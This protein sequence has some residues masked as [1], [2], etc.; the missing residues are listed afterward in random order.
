M[1]VKKT[2]KIPETVEIKIIPDS[3]LPL[4]RVYSNYVE[5]NH[6][7]FDFT[8]RFCDTTPIRNMEEVKKNGGKHHIPVVA[9]IALPVIII[10]SLINALRDQLK[11]YQA[12]YEAKGNVIKQTNK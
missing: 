6:T 7:P 1:A 12:S 10:P 8:M 3:E 4:D 9:E 2:T 5:V 11:K